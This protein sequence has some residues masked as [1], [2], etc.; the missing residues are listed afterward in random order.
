LPAPAVSP[1][2]PVTP[3][4]DAPAVP[5]P[6]TA[7][8]AVVRLGKEPNWNTHGLR[9]KT[10]ADFRTAKD[11][12][13]R[14]LIVLRY[15]PLFTLLPLALWAFLA[16]LLAWRRDEPG[17]MNRPVAALLVIGGALTIFPQYFFWRSD[18]PHLSEFMPG[19][20]VGAFAAAIL[21]GWSEVR[22]TTWLARTVACLF[23]LVLAAHA[24]L[25]L[26]RVLPERWT[27]TIAARATLKKGKD[28]KWHVNASRNTLF[29][30]ANGV[31]VFV[32]KKDY[33]ALEE[34]KAVVNAHSGSPSDYL[35][36]YP[37]HPSIN[38]LCDRRTYE[39]NVYVDNATC[40]PGWNE[41]AIERIQQYRPNVIVLSDW[42]INGTDDSRF[43]VWAEKTKTWIQT[44]YLLQ[45]K[46]LEFE[47]Y[48]RPEKEQ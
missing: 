30:G 20:W 31:D 33:A 47:V 42:A 21:L 19:Y 4:I 26:W 5:T 13:E 22:R 2:S 3:A 29:H 27:G 39:K 10:L 46:V 15:A 8:P 14:A 35:I 40:G 6:A 43:S 9:P 48:T 24:S 17:A 1:V 38:L 16:S 36:A 7:A 41:K 18:A 23:M 44:N 32:T 28:G 34:L 37:Y 25:Y 11:D 45:T 12:W